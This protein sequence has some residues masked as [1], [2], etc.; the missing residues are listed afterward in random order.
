[1]IDLERFRSLKLVRPTETVAVPEMQGRL[2]SP[3]TPEEECVLVIRALDAN[4]MYQIEEM[5]NTQSEIRRLAEAAWKVDTG[6]VAS[7]MRSIYDRERTA[8]ETCLRVEMCVRGVLNGGDSPLFDYP[9]AVKF[10]KHYPLVFQRVTD[11][12]YRLRGKPS[13]VSD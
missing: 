13:A 1:M 11:A 12:L 4:D 3:E 2:F 8:R 5:A 6:E 9:E 7:A 10:A